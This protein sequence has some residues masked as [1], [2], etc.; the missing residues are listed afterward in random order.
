[1]AGN[2]SVFKAGKLNMFFQAVFRFHDFST[3]IAGKRR[4]IFF[5][6]NQYMKVEL[7]LVL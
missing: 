5:M 4:L 7:F 2:R 1:M 3:Q 6:S